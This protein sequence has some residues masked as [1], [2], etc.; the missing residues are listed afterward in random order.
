METSLVN[1]EERIRTIFRDR[2][3]IE[4][5]LS[6][7]DLFQTGILDSLSF[8]DMLVALEEE[9]SVHI[10]LDQV[11]L[12]DFRSIAAISDHIQ[13]LNVST[14]KVGLNRQLAV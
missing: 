5:P 11:D 2:L 8:V 4:A 12:S 1:V 7:Q 10:A 9:F 3:Q 13:S 6:G 14:D